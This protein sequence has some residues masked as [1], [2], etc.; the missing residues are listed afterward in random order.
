VPKKVE[1]I[2][3]CLFIFIDT[4]ETVDADESEANLPIHNDSAS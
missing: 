1:Q 3:D 4:S 2:N